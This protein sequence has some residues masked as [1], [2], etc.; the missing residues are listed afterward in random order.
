MFTQKTAHPIGQYRRHFGGN[1][2]RDFLRRFAADVKPGWRV[3]VP[4]CKVERPILAQSSQQLG[5]TSSWTEQPNISE[6]ERQDT[7]ECEQV[8]TE[9][10]SHD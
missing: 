6:L 8:A 1:R 4:R 9:I 2:E 5:V 10:M 3:K 7:I